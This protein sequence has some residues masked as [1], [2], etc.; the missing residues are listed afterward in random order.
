MSKSNADDDDAE[1][2]DD[3]TWRMRRCH[4]HCVGLLTALLHEHVVFVVSGSHTHAIIL[5]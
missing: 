3:G 5:T 2:D 1:D 4:R